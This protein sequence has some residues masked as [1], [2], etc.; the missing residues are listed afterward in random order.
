[1]QNSSRLIGQILL[2]ALM[3]ATIGGCFGRTSKI[4]APVALSYPSAE[5]VLTVGEPVLI[6]APL[7]EGDAP[8]LW[9]VTP[10][11]PTGLALDPESGDISGTPEEA[12]PSS[13]FTITASNYGGETSVGLEIRVLPEAPCD[14]VYPLDSV[15]IL[16][17]TDFPELTPTLGCGPSSDYSVDPAL[18]EGVTLDPFSGTISGVPVISQE[19]TLHTLTAT[20]ESGSTSTTLLVEIIPA[21]PC[22]LEYEED[23]KVV[24]PFAPMA[25]ISPTTGCG[26]PDL[27]VIDPPLP[28]G[29]SIDPATGQISG[30][31]AVETPRIVYIVTASNE[32]GS[33]DTEIALRISPVFSYELEQISGDYDPVSG[34]GGGEVRIILTEGGDNVTF[35]TQILMLS[36]AL[37]HDQERLDLVSV[38]PGQD[39]TGLNDGTGPEFF[40]PFET[41]TGFTLGIVFSFSPDYGGLL[42]DVPREIAVVTYDT[43]PEVFSGDADGV[44]SDL[45]WGNPSAGDPGVPGVGN[46]VVLDGVTGI[47]PVTTDGKLDLS[48][49]DS[50]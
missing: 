8:D 5:W 32:H 15:Q 42:A 45:N 18:P 38:D 46:T 23:D 22:D 36:L 34:E 28:E 37:A 41:P 29:V 33:D 44:E 2:L 24:A 30:T 40:A 3:T 7:V 16:A 17:F 11:L 1:M 13:F 9:T 21:G 39:L 14:L 47:L 27:Y 6:P 31:P 43:I 35:P 12:C 49:S 26:E 48:P 20:N 25:P 10:D 4:T 19:P 50:D